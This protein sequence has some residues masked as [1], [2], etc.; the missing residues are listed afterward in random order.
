MLKNK[1]NNMTNKKK[2]NEGNEKKN[3][4]NPPPKTPKPLIN[5]SQRLRKEEDFIP[6]MTEKEQWQMRIYL[7]ISHQDG[8]CHIYAD[9][10]ELQCGNILRHGRFLDFRR[11][12]VTDLLNN[13]EE[14]RIKEWV[15]Q[16]KLNKRK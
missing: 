12:T 3:G 9:D 8:K 1:D 5:L 13:I 10:G 11:E 14:T 2:L 6:P 16:Q 15:E 7:A 4:N